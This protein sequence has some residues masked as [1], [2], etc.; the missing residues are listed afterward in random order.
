MNTTLLCGLMFF[1]GL[2]IGAAVMGAIRSR[3]EKERYEEFGRLMIASQYGLLAGL[4]MGDPD[5]EEPDEAISEA[6]EFEREH[7]G[8]EYG[9]DD[10]GFFHH[11]CIHRKH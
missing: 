4:G 9:V 7:E 5:G 3:W 2:L 11:H 6:L 8:C 10:E 1:P